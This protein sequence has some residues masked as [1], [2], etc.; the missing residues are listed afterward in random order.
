MHSGVLV[1]QLLEQRL[2]LEGDWKGIQSGFVSFSRSTG[3]WSG[4]GWKEGGVCVVTQLKEAS[5]VT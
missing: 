3:S 4:V 1:M 2:S 5:V